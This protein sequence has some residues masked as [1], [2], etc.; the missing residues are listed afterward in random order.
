MAPPTPTDR[1]KPAATPPA[2][3]EPATWLWR[4]RRWWLLGIPLGGLAAFLIG[5]A[6]TG[7][8]F[9]S[10]TV[11]DSEAFCTSCHSMNAPLQEL[12][13]TAHYNNAFGV[14][15]TCSN[16]HVAP[17]F[18]AGLIDHMRGSTQ[19]WG[20]MTGE[21]NTPARYE[22]HRLEL[23]Q[24]VWNEY[25]ANDSAECR[26][27]HMPAAMLLSAQPEAAASAH[28]G[29]ATSGMT[30]IDCHKGIAHTLPASG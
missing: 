28:Q 25:K 9:A 4:P 15:T 20:W 22:A 6:A 21:L 23:A 26:S 8:F 19:V 5:V 14:R 30:C 1:R 24:K 7:G 17:T 13:H 18:V 12:R 11:M 10:L 27:C 16:C 29:L 2:R 3:Q